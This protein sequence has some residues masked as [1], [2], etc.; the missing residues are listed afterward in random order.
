MKENL[1]TSKN[2]LLAY[3]IYKNLLKNINRSGILCAYCIC[4]NKICSNT[5]VCVTQHFNIV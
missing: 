5:T 4:S 1:C 3:V 2:C